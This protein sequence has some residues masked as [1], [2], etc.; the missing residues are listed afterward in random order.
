MSELSQD[1]KGSNAGVLA[2]VIA[3]PLILVF[4]IA[5]IILGSTPNPRAGA[6]ASE[7]IV[8]KPGTQDYKLIQDLKRF[9][10]P[11]AFLTDN[12][13]D[14]DS[15]QTTVRDLDNK[16][17][18]DPAY[19]S[20]PA[21]NKTKMHAVIKDILAEI[22]DIH[23][24]IAGKDL[25][26][27]KT[28]ATAIIANI[29]KLD[30]LSAQNNN[31]VAI[32]IDVVNHNVNNS[33]PY[34]AGLSV[35]QNGTIKSA[36]CSGFISYILQKGGVI[37][38]GVRYVTATLLSEAVNQPNRF[39]VILNSQSGDNMSGDN[40]QSKINSGEIVPGDLFVSRN[41][42][43]DRHVVM[44]VGGSDPQKT[45]IQSTTKGHV[46]GPQFTS[47]ADRFRIPILLVLHP[48][49]SND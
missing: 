18:S 25:S 34:V 8:P 29:S 42:D 15:F 6:Q 11:A 4:V 22:N 45:I 36:D 46:S 43:G 32:G 24:S 3:L 5:G 37:P 48:V 12:T 9:A 38:R 10:D 16:L 30:R 7:T 2:A 20:I 14:L 28:K 21:E 13:K 1:S 33:I 35:D 44:Y 17:D 47:L 39:K 49:V 41:K 26:T 40:I 27:A 23:A 31:L 19:A